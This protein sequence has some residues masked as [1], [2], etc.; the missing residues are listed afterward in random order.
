MKLKKKLNVR[1]V[2]KPSVVEPNLVLIRHGESTWNKKGVFTGWIDIG[3]SA[4]GEQEARRA[5]RLVRGYIF[6]KAYTSV[7][8]RAVKTLDL[9]L[10]ETAKKNMPV[11]KDWHLNERHYGAL[12]G[13]SKKA[14]A[15]E[16]GEKQFLAWRRSFKERPPRA[17]AAELKGQVRIA[18]VKISHL[19]KTE[20][21]YDAYKRV[22]PYW[23]KEIFPAIQKGKNILIVAHG[24]SLRAL[25]KHLEKIS[26]RT[27][28]QLEIPT[29]QPWCYQISKAG[30]V[31]KK[32]ILK[33][34]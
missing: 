1:K 21:L 14:I 22:L 9:V 17:T 27:I 16:Y 19:P 13:K 18:G 2:T 10:K 7:L 11:T 30:R 12:Q 32:W 4:T 8:K 20:S 5:G 33:K 3:L 28:P 15:K 31:N 29:G 24:N 6:D 23:K 34:K 26:D 25:V